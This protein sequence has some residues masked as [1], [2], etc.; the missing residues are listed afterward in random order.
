MFKIYDG[1]K[2]FYQWDLDRKLII[3][4]PT[5]KE[6][7]FCNRT[8]DCSLVCEV[9]TEDNLLLV[10]VPNILLQKDWRINVYAYDGNYT[11]YSKRF[12]VMSRTKPEDYVYTETELKRWETLEQ[13]IT[14]LEENGVGGGS[15]LTNTLKDALNT[16]FTNVQKL[17]PQLAYV[18]EDNMGTTVIANAQAVINALGATGGEEEPDTPINPEVT[19]TSISATY[20]GGSVAVGTA[21][22]SLTGI[23]VTGTYS[24]G[25]TATVTGYTLSGTIVE[26]TNTITVSYG[27]KTTTFTV[28]GVAESG[29]EEEPDT[30][31]LLYNWDFTNSLVDT[32]SGAEATLTAYG[33]SIPTQ[34]ENG[35]EFTT[36]GCI[37]VEGVVTT[38]RTIEVDFGSMEKSTGGHGRVL[39]M[40]VAGD[41]GIIYRSTNEWNSYIKGAWGTASALSSDSGFLS[42]K[43]LKLVIDNDGSWDSFVDDIAFV[44]NTQ[45]P[46]YELPM[47]LEIGSNNG[48]TYYNMTVTG[49]RIYEGV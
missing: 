13:R 33:S 24:D 40:G 14:E 31:T 7:H 29:G 22:T 49:L 11:K 8:D 39:M 17:F 35:I 25:S 44:S 34:T 2:E 37:S 36:N 21:L 1:R 42:G 18:K 32:V 23:T 15:G 47:R 45:L 9:Y 46:G 30:G 28:V 26:G 3:E 27:G 38:N 6:V 48:Q 20:S 41:Q 19:L 12:N 5:V 43:T 16:Y 4:D 10:D